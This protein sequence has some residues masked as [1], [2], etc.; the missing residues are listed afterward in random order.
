MAEELE[1]KKNDGRAKNTH[2][3]WMCDSNAETQGS[4]SSDACT[5]ALLHC[6]SEKGFVVELQ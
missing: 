5:F 1:D 6:L 2:T 3:D 4:S